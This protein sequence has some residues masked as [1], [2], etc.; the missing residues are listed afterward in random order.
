MKV[1]PLDSEE[2]ASWAFMLIKTDT[3]DGHSWSFR[4]TAKPN[5]EVLLGAL[6]IRVA[7]LRK[8][9]HGSVGLTVR[10]QEG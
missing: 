4:T 8:K 2:K 1:H 3:P 10:R 6:E 9:L 5:L 7:I